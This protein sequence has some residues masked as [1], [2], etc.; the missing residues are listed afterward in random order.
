MSPLIVDRDPWESEDEFEST[1]YGD[2]TID[3]ALPL[4]TEDNKHHS[5]TY[6]DS[7]FRRVEPTLMVRATGM[8]NDIVIFPLGF[9]YL[10]TFLSETGFAPLLATSSALVMS[11]FE[12]EHIRKSRFPQGIFQT[13]T[14][15]VTDPVFRPV[16]VLLLWL[17]ESALISST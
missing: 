9:L 5:V 4:H 8:L 13:P 11:E 3:C 12:C 16:I 1:D 7:K 14:P 6:L 2:G 10:M 15:Q 17:V